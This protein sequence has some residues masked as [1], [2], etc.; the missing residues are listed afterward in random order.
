MNHSFLSSQIDSLICAKCK[1]PEI[2]HGAEAQCEACSNTGP[3]ELLGSILL[4]QS[5]LKKEYDLAVQRAKEHSSNWERDKINTAI[6]NPIGA[7]LKSVEVDAALSVSTDVFNHE[8]SS[9]IELKSAIEA[10]GTN[11]VQYALAEMIQQ[12]YNHFKTVLFE[13]DAARVN[14]NSRMKAQ[15]QSLNDIASKLTAEQREQ[16]KIKDISYTPKEP[17]KKSVSKP[18]QTIEER[19]AINLMTVRFMKAAQELV[20]NGTCANIDEAKA[21]AGK[22]GLG[23]SIE[24]ARLL[25]NKALGK[26]L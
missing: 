10:S 1:R 9:I 5:C 24:Q 21:V 13:L 8:T 23:I 2:H 16:L 17:P 26:S 22:R 7:I 11:N 19:M 15:A 3:C 14:L 20:D 4:C 25:V 6:T 18:K 12:R